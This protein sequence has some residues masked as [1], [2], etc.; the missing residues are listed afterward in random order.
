M[1]LGLIIESALYGDDTPIVPREELIS[2]TSRYNS[3]EIVAA[4]R[5]TEMIEG[6]NQ[7]DIYIPEREM[8]LRLRFVFAAI[9]QN[10]R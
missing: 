6:R 5:A 9:G 4:S 10:D 1:S 3:K 7:D 8:L 2:S